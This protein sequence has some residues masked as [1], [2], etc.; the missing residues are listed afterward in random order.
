[1]DKPSTPASRQFTSQNIAH[2]LQ[3]S[4]WGSDI[5]HCVSL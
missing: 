1:M 2:P 5:T 3:K 4:C